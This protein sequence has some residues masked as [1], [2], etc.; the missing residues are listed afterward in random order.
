MPRP[1]KNLKSLLAGR[2]MFANGGEVYGEPSGILASSQP[3]MES[4][5]RPVMPPWIGPR[6]PW[7]PQGGGNVQGS[8]NQASGTL[9]T[10][11]NQLNQAAS[12]VASIRNTLGPGGQQGGFP[13]PRPGGPGWP[14]GNPLAG[15]FGNLGQQGMGGMKPAAPTPMTMAQGG[16][17]RL[18]SGG[19]PRRLPPLV[20]EL[21]VDSLTPTI[22]SQGLVR[23]QPSKNSWAIPNKITGGELLS[24]TP[25]E[26]LNRIF[27]EVLKNKYALPFDQKYPS[28]K[29][30]EKAGRPYSRVGEALMRGTDWLESGVGSVVSEMSQSV[31][32]V[33]DYLFSGQ[34]RESGRGPL[35]ARAVKEMIDMRPTLRDDILSIS[36]TVLESDPD[37]NH[38]ELMKGIAVGLSDKH[39]MP[40]VNQLMGEL[41]E[42]MAFGPKT[43][44]TAIAI[45]TSVPAEDR[46]DIAE[47]PPEIE[48]VVN[49]EIIKFGEAQA[50]GPEHHLAYVQD[51]QARTDIGDKVKE[52][53][54]QSTGVGPPVTEDEVAFQMG[55]K[56]EPAFAPAPGDAGVIDEVG[57]VQYAIEGGLLD[58]ERRDAL[59]VRLRSDEEMTKAADPTAVETAQKAVEAAAAEPKAEAAAAPD[60]GQ[61]ITFMEKDISFGPQTPDELADAANPVAEIFDKKKMPAKDAERGMDFFMNRFKEKMPKYEGMSEQ[62]KGFL[63]MDAGLRVM[64]GQSPNAI[65]NIAAGLKGVGAEFAKDAKEKRKWD[66][67]VELSAVKYGLAGVDKEEARQRALETATEPMIA[68]GPG[69]F[70]L[71]NGTVETYKKDQ[72]VLVPKSVLLDKGVPDNL[73]LPTFAAAKAKANAVNAKALGTAAN[74]FRTELIVKDTASRAIKE[75]FGK[76]TDK[77]ILGYEI[78]ALIESSFELSGKATGFTNFGKELLFKG[79]S[80]TGWRPEWATGPGNAAQREAALVT[81]MGG[82]TEYNNKIQEVSNRLL[83][84][85]LGEGS[86]NVS[87]IDRVLAQEI[88]GLVKE[89]SLGLTTNPVLL[90]QRLKRILTMADDD[91]SSGETTMKNM[92]KEFSTRIQPGGSLK[93]LEAGES[94]SGRILKPLAQQALLKR[95]A[96][97][98]DLA[99]GYKTYPNVFGNL[100]GYTFKNGKYVVDKK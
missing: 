64:A 36:K 69:K 51:L 16:V 25:G 8:V 9:G 91:I 76:A 92:Y 13:R 47:M 98:A 27:P 71:P 52:Q 3:L 67:Q 96:A 94:Y 87:N 5:R 56:G 34:E 7:G 18:Q 4:A 89:M 30:R 77:V 6:T 41:S 61:E 14:G 75:D 63:L 23:S 68:M 65:T 59:G 39:E 74:A 81:R 12:R 100:K 83:K 19:D 37:I 70:T 48:A 11:Q 58:P 35:Q 60:A 15:I 79:L 90:R 32:A 31:G 45:P 28:V 44:D 93:G 1:I 80:A 99:Q 85:L 43:R 29:A 82:R 73:T 17:A 10:A 62:E 66:R 57:A 53:V 46:P 20:Q 2:R 95:Q 88:S 49:E 33:Y 78:K 54:M 38:T 97:Q 40:E 84:R 42:G 22:G 24:Q 55:I 21:E 26:K 86:K 50:A 72:L